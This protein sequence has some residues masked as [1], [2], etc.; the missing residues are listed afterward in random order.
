MSEHVKNAAGAFDSSL[1][2]G[3]AQTSRDQDLHRFTLESGTAS[4]EF[5]IG[6]PSFRPR[7]SGLRARDRRGWGSRYQPRLDDTEG[8]HEFRRICDDIDE[9][10]R[11]LDAHIDQGV[12]SDDAA[13]VIAEIHDLLDALYDC[14]FGDGESVKSVVVALQSQVNNIQ[15]T[16]AHVGF[17]KAALQ[18]LRVRWIVNDQTVR[19]IDDMIEEFGL[20][21]FRGTVSDSEVRVRYKIEKIQD[22]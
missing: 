4:E 15:W 2:R 22:R 14:P 9:Q 21:P 6:M 1:E 13:G 3:T 10:V 19:E 8:R 11:Q 12:V 5:S 20:D 7:E 18:H 16:D 17:L